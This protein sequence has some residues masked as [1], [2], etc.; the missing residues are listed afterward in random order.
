MRLTKAMHGL[1]RTLINE[2]KDGN[3]KQYHLSEQFI[4]TISNN[5]NDVAA[6]VKTGIK[7]IDL[8]QAKKGKLKTNALKCKEQFLIG[9]TIL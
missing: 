7:E 6:V 5:G 2:M 1:F 8:Q 3:L 9:R 4:E